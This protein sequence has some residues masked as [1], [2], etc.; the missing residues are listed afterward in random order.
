MSKLPSIKPLENVSLVDKVE[1]RLLKFIKENNLKA[2]DSVPKEMEFAESLGVSRTVVRE[3]FLRLRTLGII[4]S[5]KH[6][7]MIITNP[8][9][10]NNFE[11]MLDPTL[12]GSDTL[13]NLFE[14]R[15][16]LE[17]GMAD[18]LFQH[19]TEKDMQE[20]EEIVTLEEETSYNKNAFS[21]DK[22]IAFHGKLYEMSKNDILK[23]FQ[24]LLLPVF[25]YVHLNDPNLND[26]EYSS[27]QF[28][29][30]RMLMDNLKVGTPDTF[31]VAMHRHLE[32][33]FDKIFNKK[34]K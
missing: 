26:Y 5:K 31:R 24:D 9:I 23:K 20:L 21:L 33:H 8:D 6:R 18:F 4:E 10:M 2:G 1:A 19:K 7:G 25:E 16:I 29:T 3:A 27:G 22:E 32:P 34:I 14:L 30:H 17:M 13:K 28:V 12:L 15:L 11:R